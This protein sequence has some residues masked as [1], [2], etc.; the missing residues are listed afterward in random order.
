MCSR[1]CC[2]SFFD[3]H[4]HQGRSCPPVLQ[5]GCWLMSQTRGS[6]H[7]RPCS[8]CS[9]RIATTAG[10]L[11]NGDT[12]S[13]RCCKISVRLPRTLATV[14]EHFT[15]SSIH[16]LLL[17]VLPKLFMSVLRELAVTYNSSSCIIHGQCSGEFSPPCR[18]DERL[19]QRKCHAP[20]RLSCSKYR[21]RLSGSAMSSSLC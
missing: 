17:L 19:N 10:Y 18:L 4:H 16:M 20:L 5:S 6:S 12:D 21:T 1:R 2:F 14:H 3:C 8:A 11:K 7:C 13:C 15:P 9:P